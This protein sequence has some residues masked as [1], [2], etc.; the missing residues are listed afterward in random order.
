MKKWKGNLSAFT[1]Y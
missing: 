1:H